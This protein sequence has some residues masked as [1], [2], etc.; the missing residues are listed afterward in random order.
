[1][2]VPCR[3][4]TNQ[5]APEESMSSWISLHHKHKSEN[6]ARKM[7]DME[8]SHDSI[9][10]LQTDIWTENDWWDIQHSKKHL[11]EIKIVMPIVIMK[12]EEN[13]NNEQVC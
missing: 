12:R 1:M 4:L 13:K 7:K 6:A 8:N 2:E 9:I 3:R 11:T 10:W 5:A